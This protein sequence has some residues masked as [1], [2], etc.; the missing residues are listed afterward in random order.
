MVE[1]GQFLIWLIRK[2]VSNVWALLRSIPGELTTFREA[3]RE[4]TAL[5]FLG[6]V[7]ATVVGIVAITVIM[8]PFDLTENNKSII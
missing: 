1:L 5:A 8:L 2:L 3:L 4:D 6:W 7:V